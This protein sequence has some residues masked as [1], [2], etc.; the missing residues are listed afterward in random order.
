V[1][2]ENSLVATISMVLG[3]DVSPE[4]GAIHS[5]NAFT[6]ADLADVRQ[7]ASASGVYAISYIRFK[8]SGTPSLAAAI[9]FYQ[10]VQER[11]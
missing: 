7:L 2:I 5:F 1:K 3:R 4:E 10:D 11:L 8:L 9:E 6:A